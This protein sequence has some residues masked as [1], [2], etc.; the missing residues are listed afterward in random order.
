M[1]LSIVLV[2]DNSQARIYQLDTNKQKLD[3]L[4]AIDHPEGR[5]MNQQFVTSG[6]GEST[7]SGQNVRHVGTDHSPKE[8]ESQSFART[9]AHD[10][11]HAFMVHHFDD[12]RIVAPPKLL[13]EMLPKI[14]KSVPQ[15]HHINKDLI[16]EDTEKL[17]KRLTDWH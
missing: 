17:L 4:D 11:N 14:H 8:H 7:N 16:H 13:G 3:L 2:A 5:W 12:V 15:G 1:S 10:I 6:Y 9:L